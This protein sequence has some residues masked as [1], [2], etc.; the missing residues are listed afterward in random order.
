M[1]FAVL[2]TFLF[3]ILLTLAVEVCGLV[4]FTDALFESYSIVV[5]YITIKAAPFGRFPCLLFHQD[6]KISE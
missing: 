2:G 1:E 3:G 6:N 4:L 5:G